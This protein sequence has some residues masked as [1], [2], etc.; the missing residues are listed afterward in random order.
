LGLVY[1][2]RGLVHYHHGREHDNFQADMVLKELGVLYIDLKDARRRLNYSGKQ[3]KS[4]FC[5]EEKLIKEVSKLSPPSTHN[6]TLL[7]TRPL[8]LQQGHIP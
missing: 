8:I 6:G 3:E 7:S 1:S 4:L 2:F 5:T